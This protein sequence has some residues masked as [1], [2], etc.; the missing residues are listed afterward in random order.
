MNRPTRVT[1]A[2]TTPKEQTH[3][4]PSYKKRYLNDR[5]IEAI[6]GISRRQLQRMRL[7]NQGPQFRRF[8]HKVVMYDVQML[9]RWIDTLPKG[10]ERY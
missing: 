10:G 1:T 6:Y 4:L 8:N 9:E 5:E 3:S 2:T 7:L